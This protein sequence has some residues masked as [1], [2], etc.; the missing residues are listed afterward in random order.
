MCGIVGLLRL[1]DGPPIDRGTLERMNEIQRHRGPDEGAVHLEPDVGLGNRRLAII[2]RAH[3]HQPMASDDEQVWITYNGEVYNFVELRTELQARGHTFRTLS[4]TEVVL[5]S[6]LEFGEHCVDRFN[7]QF[8]FAIWDRPRRSMF[9]ARDRLG[10]T[11]LH[12]AI[13][14]GLFVFASEAKAILEHPAFMAK[15]DRVAV[16]ETLLCGT[17]FEGRTMFDGIQMLEPGFSLTVTAEGI[18]R[19][20]YWDIP[21]RPAAEAAAEGEAYY[22]ERFV[23]M[24]EDAARIRLVGEVPWG[25]MLSGGT[26]SSTLAVLIAAMV[27]EPIQAFTID[28]PNEW[29][30]KNNDSYFADM[31]ATSIGADHRI[32]MIDP[33]DYFGVLEKI[34]WHFERPCN[35]GAASTYLLYGKLKEFATVVLSGEGADELLA[36]YVH[37][38]G[39]ALDAVTTTGRIDIFPWVPHWAAMNRLLSE[40]FRSELR[41][42]EIF[43]Q[44]LA[45]SLARIDT[46]DVLNQALYLY[47]KHFLVELIDIH[48]RTSL[49]FG[50]EGRLPFLDHRFVET[51]FSMPS[52][53]KYREG[54]TKYILKKMMAGRI[55]DGVIHRQKT[56]MPIPRDPTT[57]TNQIQMV[58]ELLMAPGSRTAGYFDLGALDHFL[59]R[60]GAFE[61][62]DMVTMWQITMY[63]ISL[64][65]HH[66]VFAL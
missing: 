32:F 24:L 49:A 47:C 23:G 18:Q 56:H 60:T 44:R 13:G 52:D 50:V 6:Y 46:D 64:E 17:L 15:V 28:F 12:Y 26:D 35:K 25:M 10:I 8:A 40:D 36:G 41:P 62:T 53:L 63:L 30:S 29:R 4:D 9:L 51:F 11:P 20:R 22:A 45:D 61:G 16:A 34:A 48:D 14:D 65:L 38:R 66:Q 19:R 27:P 43:R 57:V 39:M 31:V 2:D 54:E 37:S 33:G 55:P 7:G 1:E 5:R 58:R 59:R 3:G 42:E 21:V